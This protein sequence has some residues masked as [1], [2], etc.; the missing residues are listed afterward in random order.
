LFHGFVALII[1]R[2]PGGP[3]S[4]STLKPASCIALRTTPLQQYVTKTPPF[5]NMDNI[6]L[7]ISTVHNSG[8]AFGENASK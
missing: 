4:F 5:L 3:A 7:K 8:W 2:L 6:C 1:S